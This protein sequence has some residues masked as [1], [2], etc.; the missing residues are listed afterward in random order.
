MPHKLDSLAMKT[1]LSKIKWPFV[2][3]RP[4]QLSKQKEVKLALQLKGSA[5]RRKANK[6]KAI[7]FTEEQKQIM[8]RCLDSGVKRSGAWQK[9]AQCQ[10]EMERR[11]G[12]DYALKESQI[13]A[14]LGRCHTKLWKGEW[15][16]GTVLNS[17]TRKDNNVA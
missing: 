1:T 12:P 16:R 6:R 10:K 2:K 4:K 11:I 17:Q 14:Y 8:D 7:R 13:R 3:Q 9:H 5:S 15:N